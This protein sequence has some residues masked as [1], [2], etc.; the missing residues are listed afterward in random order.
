[1]N[2][3]AAW[4]SRMH[5]SRSWA[6]ATSTVANQPTSE[7]IPE[8]EF[9]TLLYPRKEYTLAYDPVGVFFWD[10]ACQDNAWQAHGEHEPSF[11]GVYLIPHS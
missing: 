3:S 8:G 5:V 9:D 6:E 2:L 11:T 7:F 10:K 4:Q 1:M